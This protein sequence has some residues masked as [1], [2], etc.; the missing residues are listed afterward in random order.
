MPWF[1]NTFTFAVHELGHSLG[2]DHSSDDKAIMYEFYDGGAFGDALTPDDIAAIRALYA[3]EY[4]TFSAH[5]WGTHAWRNDLIIT[6]GVKDTVGGTTLWETDV[7]L[8]AGGNLNDFDYDEI[9]LTDA[10]A[11]ADGSNDWFVS[12]ED[13]AAE[14]TGVLSGFTIRMGTPG[15]W[16][17]WT[18]PDAGALVDLG[19]KMAYIQDIP[20]PATL[21]LLGAGVVLMLARRR[22]RT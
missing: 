12:V 21:G 22:R 9:D 17:E 1:V 5:V 6:L 2:I 14:D 16:T 7:H 8:R 10:A 13:T 11:F 15:N 20:E 3:A 19:T 4:P 18:S